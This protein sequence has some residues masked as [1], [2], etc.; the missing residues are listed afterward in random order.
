MSRQIIRYKNE[1]YREALRHFEYSFLA[2][3][4]GDELVILSSD[5]VA[6]L[7]TLKHWLKKAIQ[8]SG[9]QSLIYTG[10]K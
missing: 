8:L 1:S 7:R 9:I 3:I 4:N 2:C 6:S 10:H 5:Q